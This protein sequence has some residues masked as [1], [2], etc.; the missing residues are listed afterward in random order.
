M[1]L[2]L[3]ESLNSGKHQ[4]LGRCKVQL[5]HRGKG[6]LQHGLGRLNAEL[7]QHWCGL[8]CGRLWGSGIQWGNG[9]V[10]VGQRGHTLP[11]RAGLQW[12]VL[13]QAAE[14][15]WEEKRA[16]LTQYSAKDINRL[17][18]ETQAELM[19]AIPD[20]EFAAK[21]KQTT[22]SSSAASTPEHKPSKPQHAQKSTG[23]V[24][25]N[26][27]RGSGKGRGR[28]LPR[29]C[30]GLGARTGA[31]LGASSAFCSDELTVP[32]YRTEKPSKSPP[33]PPPRRSFPS[34]HG[35]TTTRSGE[36]IVTSK[37]EP[38]FMK[39]G[40][41]AGHMVVTP[42]WS[43][44]GCSPL[45]ALC[46]TESRIGR[47]GDPEATGEA[48]TDGVRGGETCIHPTHHRLCHQR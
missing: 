33:P 45:T 39:V 27:R 10:M 13:S 29:V 8:G 30:A 2:E 22:G 11:I 40:G 14:R 43:P 6:G 26:G 35:L 12:A 46:P 16:A 20:L 23:K 42:W 48:E 5:G 32:R 7:E 18:E 44:R 28:G 19:K 17:L 3:M 47:A 34:S 21:H 36:V 38:G 41:G 24:D 25:A 9:E 15:D 31:R 1:G 4:I 37:K